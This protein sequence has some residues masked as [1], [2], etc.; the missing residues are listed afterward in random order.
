MDEKENNKNILNLRFLF[1]LVFLVLIIVGF[2]YLFIK[3][4]N[5]YENN[6][7]NNKD[8]YTYGLFFPENSTNFLIKNINFCKDLYTKIHKHNSVNGKKILTINDLFENLHFSDLCCSR[9][10]SQTNNLNKSNNVMYNSLANYKQITINLCYFSDIV[11]NLAEDIEK[12]LSK[13]YPKN[14]QIN[15]KKILKNDDLFSNNLENNNNIFLLKLFSTSTK[16]DYSKIEFLL[17]LFKD[18]D[19]ISLDISKNLFNE[20]EKKLLSKLQNIFNSK[21]WNNIKLNETQKE[22]R[23]AVHDDIKQLIRISNN[24]DINDPKLSMKI[25]QIKNLFIAIDGDT[26]GNGINQLILSIP[27]YNDNYISFID[28]IKK[29]CSQIITS[30]HDSFLNDKFSVIPLKEIEV[31]SSKKDFYDFNNYLK[32]LLDEKL[33]DE[34]IQ[35][36]IN[37]FVEP[38]NDFYTTRREEIENN[39]DGNYS[40]TNSNKNHEFFKS[41]FSQEYDRWKSLLKCLQDKKNEYKNKNRYPQITES[42]DNLIN[43]SSESL[44]KAYDVYSVFYF[45]LLTTDIDFFDKQIKKLNQLE[46]MFKL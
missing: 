23:K 46:Y 28:L 38:L 45:Y 22:L 2:C 7:Y 3:N 24:K 15:I 43:I 32:L 44:D 6:K 34:R 42:I 35:K 31:D 11:K 36:I 9:I 8:T 20:E 18:D 10:G 40:N 12:F 33:K 27:K 29:L 25:K 26:L 30:I 39:E 21:N 41:T 14:I 16:S 13:E 37:E 17:N 5:Y 1:F 4:F 19:V